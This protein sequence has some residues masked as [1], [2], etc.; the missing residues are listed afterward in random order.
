MAH[1]LEAAGTS[2][3]KG[4]LLKFCYYIYIK[5]QMTD[6]WKMKHSNALHDFTEGSFY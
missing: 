4:K 1:I 5:E 2:F 6:S 3:D